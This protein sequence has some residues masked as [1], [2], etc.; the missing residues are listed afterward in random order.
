M[1]WFVP[2]CIFLLEDTWV[3][4]RPVVKA[5]CTLTSDPVKS[6]CIP[7]ENG[8]HEI[9]THNRGG[10]LRQVGTD[11]EPHVCN[12][13]TQPKVGRPLS[14][15]QPGRHS[16]LQ[17]NVGYRERPYP[18]SNDINNNSNKKANTHTHG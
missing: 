13:S 2:D 16:D 5:C 10:Y 12:L 9:F 8:Y 18:N 4:T 11:E 15:V 1:Y 6:V 14:P 3:D 7:G 17:S